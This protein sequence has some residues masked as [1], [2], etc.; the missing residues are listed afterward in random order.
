MINNWRKDIDKNLKL[1]LE[2]IEGKY[3]LNSISNTLFSALKDFLIRKG[4]RIRPLL[5][6]LAYQGYSKKNIPYKG[7]IRS[8]LAF[9][10][11]H[12]FMLIHDDIIDKAKLRRG[13]PTLQNVFNK[14]LRFTSAN[15]LGS[16]LSIVAGDLTFALSVESFLAIEEEPKLKLEALKKF[17]E[18]AVFT[19]AGEFIDITNAAKPIEKTRLKDVSLIYVLKTAKYTFEYPLIIAAILAGAERSEL[20]KLSKMAIF[21]GEAFQ[22]QD[23]LL[24]IFSTSKIIGKPVLSDLSESK[25]TLVLWKTYSN[26]KSADKKIIEKLLEKKNKNYSDFIKFR[27]LIKKSGAQTYCLNRIDLLLK[28]VHKIL[29]TLKMKKKFKLLLSGFLQSLF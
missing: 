15:E 23:D 8:A 7:L 14:K 6:L 27:A 11:L 28:K 10:L 22:I 13:K 9:E 12:D 26:L 19:S 5:F 29:S 21:A 24:D 25:K 4:K 16:F 3:K 20:N 18:S 1:F 2:D 17:S